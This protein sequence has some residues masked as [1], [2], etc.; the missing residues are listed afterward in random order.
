[1]IT[2]MLGLKW[3]PRIVTFWPSLKPVD[4]VT[5]ITAFDAPTVC[6]PV[7]PPA[8]DECDPEGAV[9]CLAVVPLDLVAWALGDAWALALA[10]ADFDA[11]ALGPAVGAADVLLIV[12]LAPGV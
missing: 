11:F 7:G 6:V 1:M 5:V 10:P 12:G 4:G 8:G 3:V 2:A 9:E